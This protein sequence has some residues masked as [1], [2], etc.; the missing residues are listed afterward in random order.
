MSACWRNIKRRCLGIF[1]SAKSHDIF[2]HKSISDM[3]NCL[4]LEFPPVG[5]ERK[6]GKRCQASSPTSGF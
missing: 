6:T 5:N 4:T 2:S 3:Q 1:H